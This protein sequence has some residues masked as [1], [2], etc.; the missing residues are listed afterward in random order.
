[1]AGRCE[2]L[3]PPHSFLEIQEQEPSQRLKSDM[4]V[5]APVFLLVLIDE[6]SED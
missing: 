1:M 4:P 5:K 6:F 3:A 2:T